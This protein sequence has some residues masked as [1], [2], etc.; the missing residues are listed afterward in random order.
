MTDLGNYSITVILIAAL[1]LY[2]TESIG[3]HRTDFER[4]VRLTQWAAWLLTFGFGVEIGFSFVTRDWGD[5]AW[6]G[7]VVVAGYLLAH[8]A[9]SNRSLWRAKGELEEH[10]TEIEQHI[11]MK[12]V[13]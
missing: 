11:W 2:L 13:P 10:L 8:V 4:R 5:V 1:G 3:K 7:L 6:M 9:R 12:D